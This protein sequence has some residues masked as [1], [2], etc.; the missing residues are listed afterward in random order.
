MKSTNKIK[1]FV[2][3][4]LTY[5]TGNVLSK[6]VAFFLLP[7]YTSKLLPAEYGT[8]DLVISLVNLVAPIAFFQIWDGMFRFAFD[9][10]QDKDKYSIISNSC[11]AYLFGIIIYITIFF[12]INLYYKFDYFGLIICYGF[13]FALQYMYTYAAR[14]FLKNKLFS[15]SGIINT[16][17]S[18]CLN[19]ILITKFNSGVESLY[20]SSS[21][22]CLIQIIIIELNLKIIKNFKLKS[23]N[24][25]LI[26]KMLKF[27]LPLCVATISYWLL[28]GFTKVIITQKLGADEN[29]IYAVANRFASTVTIVVNVFQYAWNEMAYLMSSD[30]KRK[31][32]Y[33]LCLDI[34][35]KCTLI[36]SGIIFLGV[37]IIFP[38][39]IDIKYAAATKIVPIII[40]GVSFNSLAG[41]IGTFFMT[42]KQTKYILQSTM[43]G[44]IV[45]I[46][47][48]FILI[49]KLKLLGATIALSISFLILLLSRL[50]LLKKQLK[51]SIS[52]SAIYPTTIIIFSSIVY[53]Y[54]KNT[55]IDILTIIISLLT[56]AIM[57][58][59]KIKKNITI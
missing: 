29:G 58:I 48:S 33:N 45:N 31:E 19:I 47:L 13:L 35:L 54:N 6:L 42:E 10:K 22:G 3:T 18:A 23:I 36:S 32:K 11:I 30:N 17:I 34:I 59:K 38:Y 40:L 44:A 52:P 26:K 16:F 25:N 55:I 1:Q 41:F 2:K 20:I 21:C 12:A 7:L 57:I 51:I 53:Y 15:I 4:A 50:L 14:V 37:K 8:Y 43:I 9:Y 46:I 39:F 5:L 56:L 28:S 27:S 49:K 24:I